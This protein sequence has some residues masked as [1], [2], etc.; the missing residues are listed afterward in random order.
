MS[1][2]RSATAVTG[3][4]RAWRVCAQPTGS[5]RAVHRMRMSERAV[6]RMRMRHE[7][8]GA[9]APTSTLSTERS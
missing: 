4:R 3:C 7:G 8:R 5:E 9:V 2:R 1:K 6:H